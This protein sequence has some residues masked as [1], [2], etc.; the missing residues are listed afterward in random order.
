VLYLVAH[1]GLVHKRWPLRRVPR[2]GYLKRQLQ[3]QRESKRTP[4][5]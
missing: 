4:T 5:A 1:D 2:G 3:A